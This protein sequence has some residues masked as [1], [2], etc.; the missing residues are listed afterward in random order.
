MKYPHA[1]EQP[2]TNPEVVLNLWA[3][4]SE[5]G[6]IMRLAGKAY[7]LQGN[8]EDKLAMLRALSGTDFLCAPWQKVPENF[9]MINPD[10][11][12]MNGIAHCSLLSEQSSHGH[13]FGPL[14]EE[15]ANSLPEQLRSL[16]GD[17]IQF[18]MELPE[19]PLTVTTVVME[20]EDGRLV[21][22]VSGR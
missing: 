5:D 6:Y 20:Y 8:D 21:P 11:R 10:G 14:I 15:I 3:Y 16:S 2:L 17:Y 1:E 22:M 4:S 18:Q 19:D 13:L 9:T 12:E 7:A